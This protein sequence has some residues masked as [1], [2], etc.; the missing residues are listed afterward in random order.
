M[1][2]HPYLKNLTLE[3]RDLFNDALSS[4]VHKVYL[5]IL[6]EI[7]QEFHRPVVQYRLSDMTEKSLGELAILKANS[8][9]AEALLQ[10]FQSLK[11]TL[12]NKKD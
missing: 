6:A 10:K 12:K 2:T 4:D 8:Q 9:G 7:T 11:Q 5:K 3:E 1:S